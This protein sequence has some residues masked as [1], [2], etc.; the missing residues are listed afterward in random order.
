MG[1]KGEFLKI[2]RVRTLDLFNQASKLIN[3]AFM[4]NPMFSQ[5]RSP[6]AEEL[7]DT[8]M[9]EYLDLEGDPSGLPEFTA[10]RMNLP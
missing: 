9:D 6:Y 5:P 2:R 10:K 1:K 8:I 7:F 4:A 3:V